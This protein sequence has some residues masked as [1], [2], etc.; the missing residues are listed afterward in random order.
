VAEEQR[1]FSVVE[2]AR[3]LGVHPDSL[4]RA[5]REGRLGAIRREPLSGTRFFTEAEVEN[6]RPL[7]GTKR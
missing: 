3:R 2:A 7:I 1:I 4:R 6:I 5:D